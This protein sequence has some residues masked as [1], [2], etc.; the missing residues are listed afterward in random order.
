MKT[1]L[2]IFLTLL[3]IALIYA[4]G[5]TKESSSAGGQT[6]QPLCGQYIV[7]SSSLADTLNFLSWNRVGF[8]TEFIPPSQ[9]FINQDTLVVLPDKSYFMY[10]ISEDRSQLFGMEGW[11][12]GDT[13]DLV[14]G[15]NSNCPTYQLKTADENWL[16][17]ERRYHEIVLSRS[18]EKQ[19]EAAPALCEAGHAKS[20]INLAVARFLKKETS[21]VDTSLLI[22]AGELGDYMGYFRL[23]ETLSEQ[24]QNQRAKFYFDKACAMG[25]QAS[26]MMSGLMDMGEE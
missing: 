10:K 19:F 5:T 20:C 7:R 23:G 2:P 14:F 21:M 13:L 22:R 1:K 6:I 18:Y 15:T 8:M 9:Y 16:A 25:H 11:V 3:L 17:L 12:K 24:N 4:C 26:C